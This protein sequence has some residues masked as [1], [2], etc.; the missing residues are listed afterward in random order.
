V[1]ETPFSDRKWRRAEI[2]FP[3]VGML[4]IPLI[5]VVRVWVCH[6]NAGN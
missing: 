5:Q 4:A 6:G 1:S 3:E 2:K